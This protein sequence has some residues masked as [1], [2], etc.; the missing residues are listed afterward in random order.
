MTRWRNAAGTADFTEPGRKQEKNSDFYCNNE[1]SEGY[2]LPTTY[3]DCCED[4]EGR[5]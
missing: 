1:N 5:Q 4:W 3:E 2:G